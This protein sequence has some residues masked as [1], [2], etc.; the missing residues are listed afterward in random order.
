MLAISRDPN[1]LVNGSVQLQQRVL[2]AEQELTLVLALIW[3]LHGSARGVGHQVV[4]T[5]SECFPVHCTPPL[6][7]KRT[8][9]AMQGSG[10]IGDIYREFNLETTR[11]AGTMSNSRFDSLGRKEKNCLP[12]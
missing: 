5:H 12:Y 1:L 11:G 10:Y 2:G 3:I 9:V 4:A 6:P 8:E 7:A